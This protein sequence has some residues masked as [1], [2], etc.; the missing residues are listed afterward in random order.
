MNLYD[1]HLRLSLQDLYGRESVKYSLTLLGTAC[2]FF[3]LTVLCVRARVCVR[4]CVRALS[5]MKIVV[6]VTRNSC[7][8]RFTVLTER[9]RRNVGLFGSLL[10]ETALPVRNAQPEVNPVTH[11]NC[12]DT[13][14]QATSRRVRLASLMNQLPPALYIY[15]LTYLLT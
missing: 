14:N 15:Q 3:C 11:P 12:E 5:A 13:D 1:L 4:V 7:V 10:Q 6:V 2:S 8:Q 9:G